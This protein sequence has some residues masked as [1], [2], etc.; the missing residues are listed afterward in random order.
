MKKSLYDWCIENNKE[1]LLAEWDCHQNENLDT[2]EIG[3][4]SHKR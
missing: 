1:H 3:Y 4:G 2:K